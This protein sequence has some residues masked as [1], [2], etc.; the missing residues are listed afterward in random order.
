VQISGRLAVVTGAS[1]GIGEA[2]A[3][4]LGR[5]GARVALVARSQ[6]PLEAVAAGVRTGGGTAW[7][8]PADLSRPEE[9][10]RVAAAI[11]AEAGLPDLLV[12]NAGAGRWRAVDETSLEEAAELIAVP[13]LAA[14]GMTRAFLPGMIARGSGWIVNVTSAVAHLMVPGAT[15]YGVARWAMRAFSAG[16]RADLRGTGVGVTLVTAGKVST[17]YFAHNPGSEERIPRIARLAP[18]LS[19]EEVAEAMLRGVERERREVLVPRLVR[20]LVWAH[21]HWPGP[22]GALIDL[23]GWRRPE[24]GGAGRAPHG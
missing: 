12:N 19:P 10:A 11:Q 15:A 1:S 4:L 24:G 2:A 17:P 9:I 8:F 22:V 21:R 6:G 20:F 23:G 18:T 14:F 7:A 3:R 16:L 13:Y 5:R